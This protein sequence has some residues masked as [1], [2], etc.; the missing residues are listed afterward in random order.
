MITTSSRYNRNRLAPVTGA[1]GVT[2]LTILPRS[3]AA[4]TYSVQ[5]YTWGQHDR[6]DLLARRYY[7]SEQ[8]WW[9]FADANPQI[10][11]W[12]AVQPG[13]VIRIPVSHG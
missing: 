6:L 8:L 13:T 5:Y 4:A 1:D 2:R 10:T 11:N 12:F 3:P 7:G 9:I